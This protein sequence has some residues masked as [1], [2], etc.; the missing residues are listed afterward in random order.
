M[1]IRRSGDPNQFKTCESPAC[2]PTWLE[3]DWKRT[4]VSPLTTGQFTSWTRRSGKD[5]IKKVRPHMVGRTVRGRRVWRV[6]ECGQC[7]VW[8]V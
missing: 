6:W 3:E 7:R 4:L 1:V 8:R 5:D 2:L